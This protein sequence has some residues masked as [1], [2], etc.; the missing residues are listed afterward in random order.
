M[1]GKSENSDKNRLFSDE[2]SVVQQGN[3]GINLL[4]RTQFAVSDAHSDQI[5][6]GQI[7]A[8]NFTFKSVYINLW[9]K[10]NYNK[11]LKS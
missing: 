6:A 7:A 11:I 1:R 8:L 10:L 2:S 4:N 5:H 9:N 3:V